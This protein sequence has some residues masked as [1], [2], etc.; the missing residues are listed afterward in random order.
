MRNYIER[1]ERNKRTAKS[2]QCSCNKVVK[3]H[4]QNSKCT[5]NPVK[6]N[7]TPADRSPTQA[8]WIK[9][10]CKKTFLHI[11]LLCIALQ[12]THTVE[13]AIANFGCQ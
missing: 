10:A 8:W 2:R 4:K 13:I 6:D 5:K 3:Q 11:W 1:N 12:L 9:C 7:A